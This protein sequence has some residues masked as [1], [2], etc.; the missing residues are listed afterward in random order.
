VHH[1]HQR[2]GNAAYFECQS[3]GWLERSPFCL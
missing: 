3:A 2:R 1:G